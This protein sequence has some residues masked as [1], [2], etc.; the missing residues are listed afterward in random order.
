MTNSARAR[1]LTTLLLAAPPAAPA[2]AAEPQEQAEARDAPQLAEEVT[3]T[4]RER[5]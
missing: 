2:P 1:L 3:V 4:A 5:E